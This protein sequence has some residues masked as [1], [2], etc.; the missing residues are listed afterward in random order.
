MTRAAHKTSVSTKIQALQKRLYAILEMATAT[1]TP[2]RIVDVVLISLILF[3]VL[4][5]ILD[6]VE[7]LVTRYGW[8][9]DAFETGSIVIFTVEYLLRLW[10]CTVDTR[11]AHP[12]FGRLRFVVTPMA[13]VDLC[14]LLPFYLPVMLALDLRFIRALRLFRLFRVF[15][16]GHYSQSL[17][18]FAQVVRDKRAELGV[19]VCAVMVLLIFASSFMYYIESEAQPQAFSSIP[20]AMWWGVATLTTVGYGDIYPIT[21]LGKILGA[22]IALLGIGLF[23]V[24]AGILASGFTE[25]MERHS[26]AHR[27]C[28]HCGL[29]LDGTSE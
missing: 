21:P 8:W 13:L 14:A 27:S 2:S 24:P 28:P 19:A 20:A 9:L 6:T 18:L 16:L 29:P 3:N 7:G 10:V 1:D 25:V 15:K 11:F 4:A 5:V 26:T 23:A 12:V 22:I 17:Q